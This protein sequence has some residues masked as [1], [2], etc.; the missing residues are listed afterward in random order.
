MENKFKIPIIC[1]VINKV[2]NIMDT[3]NNYQHNQ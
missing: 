3:K 2:S 1:D